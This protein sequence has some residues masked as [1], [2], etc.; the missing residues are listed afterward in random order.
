MVKPTIANKNTKEQKTMIKKS[1][2]EQYKQ[3]RKEYLK[4]KLTDEQW[5]EFCVKCLDELL[6]ENEKVLEKLKNI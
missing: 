1:N 5:Y 3:V 6:V 4:G 2:L